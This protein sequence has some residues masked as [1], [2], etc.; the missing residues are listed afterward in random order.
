M[1]WMLFLLQDVDVTEVFAADR[2][3]SQA[4][5]QMDGESFKRML[6]PEAVFLGQQKLQGRDAISAAWSVFLKPDRTLNLTWSP[7]QGVVAQSQDLAF[8][9][10][11]YAMTNSQDGSQQK[12]Q[13]LT[14]WRRS[15]DGHWLAMGDAPYLRKTEGLS[16]RVDAGLALVT[17][18]SVAACEPVPLQQSSDQTLAYAM[19]SYRLKGS[20]RSHFFL[21][22]FSKGSGP[23]EPQHLCAP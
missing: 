12:G 6:H 19:G 21:A 22:V 9:I 15:S 17:G 4:V 18:D 1:W 7:V 13:Y 14:V 5:E 11:D 2:E 20:E 16:Y 8:T 3:F 10:G 23:W